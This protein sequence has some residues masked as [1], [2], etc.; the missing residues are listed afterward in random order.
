MFVLL[1][2]AAAK[3]HWLF[4]AS[5]LEAA[6]LLWEI[7]PWH[8]RIITVPFVL[9]SL[10]PNSQHLMAAFKVFSATAPSI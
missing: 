8:G 10:S 1:H 7:I 3:R 6:E 9:S 5:L 2:L 4:G